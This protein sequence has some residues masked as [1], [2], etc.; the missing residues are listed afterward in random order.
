MPNTPKPYRRPSVPANAPRRWERYFEEGY[1]VKTR[2]T[3]AKKDDGLGR[4]GGLCYRA[5]THAASLSVHSHR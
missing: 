3:E 2:S 5:S 1:R 4:R